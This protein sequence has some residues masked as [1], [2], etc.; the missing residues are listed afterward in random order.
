M[1]RATRQRPYTTLTP[2]E[3]EY[4]RKRIKGYFRNLSLLANRYVAFHTG[5]SPGAAAEPEWGDKMDDPI[6]KSW[7]DSLV[8]EALRGRPKA[9]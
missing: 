5:A 2:E 6:L 7:I 3:A 9:D 4:V 1:R 8:E